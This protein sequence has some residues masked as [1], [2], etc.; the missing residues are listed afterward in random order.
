MARF[1][2]HATKFLPVFGTRAPN[3]RLAL[4]IESAGPSN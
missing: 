3:L 4:E 2:G 1:S